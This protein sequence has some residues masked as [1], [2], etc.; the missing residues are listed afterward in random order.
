MPYSLEDAIAPA[1]GADAADY[2]GADDL[3]TVARRMIDAS[4]PSFDNCHMRQLTR[5]YSHRSNK[6][7]TS[8][9]RVV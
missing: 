8:I 6:C 5:G 2:A 1:D 3:P 4:I 7:D 9:Q